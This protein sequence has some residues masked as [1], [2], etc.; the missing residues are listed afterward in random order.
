[1]VKGLR[2][3]VYYLLDKGLSTYYNAMEDQ[4]SLIVSIVTALL[5]GGIII[6]FLENQ[7]VGAN[8]AERF[9]F[10][11]K[12]FMHKLS[13]Y[14]KFLSSAKVYFRIKN[15]VNKEEHSYVF[16]LY[17]LMNELGHYAHPCIMSGQDYPTSH[18]SSKEL[19]KL[20]EDI[21]NVWYYWG[22]KQFYIKPYCEYDTNRANMFCQFGQSYLNEIFP[23]EYKKN[24]FSMDLISE[25]SGRF[26]TDVYQPI[27]NVPFEY[28]NWCKEEY[29]FKQIILCAIG[30]CIL[31]LTLI[32]FLR[33]IIPLWFF[34]MLALLTIFAFVYSI[35]KFCKIESLSRKLFK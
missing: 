26:F 28:E 21:N 16:T 22:E 17:N 7:H 19:Q 24:N 10:I 30:L 6:L 20:C 14:F 18:F 32:L 35:F 5:T 9:Q 25:V 33:Y 12:P 4:T 3:L 1:M 23:N 34:N 15:G 2:Q 8:V 11:M 31:L 13:N 27:Q 29:H